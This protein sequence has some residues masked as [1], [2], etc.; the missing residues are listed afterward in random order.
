MKQIDEQTT[1]ELNRRYLAAA[2]TVGG[3]FVLTVILTAAAALL[4]GKFE[5]FGAATGEASF[6]VEKLT[7]PNAAGSG[8]TTFLWI[9]ILALAV[10]AFLLRRAIF[11]SATLRDTA[12]LKGASGLLGSL[13]TKTVLL[14]AFGLIIAI[15]GLIVALASGNWT[16]AVRA[17]AVA[18]IV[19]F[20]N[21]PRKAAWRRLTQAVVK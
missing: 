19:L 8:L 1:N 7:D 3:F 5:P 9:T 6:N 4:A 15:L 14:A 18:S 17:A 20:V 16:D 10:S 21:F 13:Q 11:A 2:L 12:T